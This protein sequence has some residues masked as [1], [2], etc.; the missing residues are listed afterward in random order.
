MH[1]GEGEGVEEEG[2]ADAPLREEPDTRLDL[3][4]SQDPAIKT[5]GKQSQ[6]L[7]QQKA[8]QAPLNYWI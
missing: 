3:A 1:V 6:M 2:D 4:W 7:N 5:W 8:T